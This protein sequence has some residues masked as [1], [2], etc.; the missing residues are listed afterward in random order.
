[1]PESHLQAV[2]LAA[3]ESSRFWPLNSKHKSLTRIAGEPLI[4][5]TI[6][7]LNAAEINNTVIVQGPEAAV[8]GELGKRVGVSYVTQPKPDGMGDAVARA[9]SSGSTLV[10]HAHKVDAGNYVKLMIDRAGKSGAEFVLVGAKTDNP[11]LYGVLEL[12]GDRVTGLIEKP[13]KGKEPSNIR[14]VGSYLLPPNFID[15]YKKVPFNHYA[16]ED[17]LNLY[18]KENGARL[19]M[20]EGGNSLKYPWQLFETTK[21]LLD[22]RLKG[23]EIDPTAKIAKSAI[24]D[25]NVYIGPNTKVFE[26][27]VIKGPCYIGPNCVI[28][29]NAVVRD[30]TN[31]EEGAMVGALAEVARSIFQKGAHVHSGYCGDSILG[32]GCRIGAGT[33]TANVRLDRGEIKTN[34]KGEKI[35]TGLTSLGAIVGANTHI[36]VNVSLMP[37]VLIGSNCVVGPGTV[38]SENI[39]DNTLFYAKPLAIVDKKR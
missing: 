25:G 15:Y 17:A 30:Y 32:E 3:G 39:E 20:S 18:A 7:G 2:I 14:V 34:V 1:M 35:N 12:E 5:H 11:Q 33:V 27:A 21:Y 13:E 9:Q 10:F 16:F 23:Q 31:L 36:G 24:I 19:V 26:G 28:G 4:L 38:V 6:K 37:G 29:N 8:E 22:S